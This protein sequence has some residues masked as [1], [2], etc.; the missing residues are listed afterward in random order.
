MEGGFLIKR[1]KV[2][3]CSMLSDI[4]KVAFVRSLKI[5]LRAQGYISK[6]IIHSVGRGS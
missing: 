1:S 5:M 6:I 2:N 3:Q 4:S